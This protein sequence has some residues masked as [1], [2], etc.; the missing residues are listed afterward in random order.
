MGQNGQLLT[1]PIHISIS[2]LSGLCITAVASSQNFL[3][4][5]A[6]ACEHNGSDI[7]AAKNTLKTRD[8]VTNIIL[9][10]KK[11]IWTRYIKKKKK[12]REE[13]PYSDGL[14]LVM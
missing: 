1:S 10:S 8:Q 12:N 4:A 3:K 5:V 7:P 6:Q 9:I 14:T 11:R 2:K 13:N